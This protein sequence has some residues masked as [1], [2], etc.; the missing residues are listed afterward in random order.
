M[1]KNLLSIYAGVLTGILSKGP[2]LSIE[3]L[4][5]FILCTIPALIIEYR[6]DRIED[7]QK[8]DS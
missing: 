5:Y 1:N 6:L 4:K 8:N 7:K 2:L 3:T